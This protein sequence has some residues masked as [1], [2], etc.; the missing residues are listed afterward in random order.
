MNR[1]LWVGD[2][3]EVLRRLDTHLVDLVYAD[4]PFNSGRRYGTGDGFEDRWDC[5]QAPDMRD[6]PPALLGKVS[7]LINSGGR[8]D[9]AHYLAFMAPRLSE[10]RRVL[11]PG[12]TLYL[13][14]DHH[15]SHYLR[16]LLDVIFGADAFRNEIIWCY[17]SGGVSSQRFAQK[18]DLIFCYATE[19]PV[20]FNTPRVPYWSSASQSGKNRHRFHTDGKVMLDWWSDIPILT[21][22]ESERTGWPTQ[23]PSKLLVRIIEASS[24]PGDM[25]LDPFVGSGTTSVAAEKLGR[26][27]CGIDVSEHAVE[28]SRERLDR[29]MCGRMLSGSAQTNVVQTTDATWHTSREE[30]ATA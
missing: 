11:R 25:V 15:A 4:P 6:V 5:D 28:I 30:P 23:K 10:M 29:L 2:N 17:S 20:T 8:S 26:R 16:I 24:N 14:C 13:H 21:Q 19:G 18:H 7:G 12:G 3:L 1:T 22:N 9:M 27:W